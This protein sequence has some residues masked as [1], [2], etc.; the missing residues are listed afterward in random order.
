LPGRLS[1]V[2]G[3]KTNAFYDAG[4]LN[5]DL[6]GKSIETGAHRYEVLEP[7]TAKVIA[8]FTT[9][10]DH[11]PAVTINEFGKGHA[12]YLATESKS[13]AIGLVLSHIYSIVGVHPGPETPE[14]VYARVVDG[15]TLYVNTTGEK[16]QISIEGSKRGIIS[17]REYSGTIELEPQEAD[18]IE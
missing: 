2:F 9:T 13:S 3:L 5:F 14:G 11:A 12:I 16:K 7:S 6:D 1:D 8:R 18:L 10:T 4:R 17:N 15:R